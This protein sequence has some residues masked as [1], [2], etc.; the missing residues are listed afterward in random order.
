MSARA[1]WSAFA[2]VV[3]LLVLAVLPAQAHRLKL[4]ATVENG[5]IR[6]QAFFIGG[7]APK[8]AVVVFRDEKGKELHRARTN[9]GGH[10]S[11]RPGTVQSIT[12][13]LN[14][15]DG[16]AVRRKL[17]AKLFRGTGRNSNAGNPMQPAGRDMAKSA[18]ANSVLA[19]QPAPLKVGAGI[20][21]LLA[22]G[23]LLLWARRRNGAQATPD[24]RD[25]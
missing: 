22:A 12:I 24:G 16:H 20:A 18:L 11:W 3:A 4:F 23:G 13:I 17:P 8:G 15:G 1:A 14:V 21:A 19:E 10:F 25:S 5:E 9:A 6:G 2:V 7:G